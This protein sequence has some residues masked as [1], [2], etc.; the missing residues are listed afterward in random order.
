MRHARGNW[1]CKAQRQ[2]RQNPGTEQEYVNGLVH[3]SPCM[4]QADKEGNCKN[5]VN[6][7]VT[8]S[9]QCRAY[10]I[11]NKTTPMNVAVHVRIIKWQLTDVFHL[12]KDF[13]ESVFLVLKFQFIIREPKDAFPLNAQS[14]I[15]EID[16]EDIAFQAIRMFLHIE[17]H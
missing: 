7:V 10:R 8:Q 4:G 2:N 3:K 13:S 6:W 11:K 9:G 17:L 12:P 16:D 15:L 5:N 1:T 14:G